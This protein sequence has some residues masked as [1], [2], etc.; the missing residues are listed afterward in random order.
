MRTIKKSLFSVICLLCLFTAFALCGC[1]NKAG[2]YVKDSLNYK[3]SSN[4]LHSCIFDGEFKVYFYKPGEY[5]VKF[6]IKAESDYGTHTEDYDLKYN[7]VKKG[8]QTIAITFFFE[9]NPRAEHKVH[10]ENFKI[11]LLNDNEE[12]NDNKNEESEYKNYAIG[13]GVTAGVILLGLITI[14]ILDATGIIKKEKTEL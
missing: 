7:V 11:T 8:N 6:Q 12:N 14:F 9:S 5:N 2:Y 1:S 10:I 4:M 13:F 3:L